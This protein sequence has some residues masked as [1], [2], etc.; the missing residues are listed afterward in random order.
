MRDNHENFSGFY[1]QEKKIDPERIFYHNAAHAEIRE[2]EAIDFF[3]SKSEN[4]MKINR[5]LRGGAK[6]I[7]EAQ[8]LIKS[9]EFLKVKE[10][11]LSDFRKFNSKR[12]ENI[13]KLNALLKNKNLP[14]IKK[15]LNTG[16]D[17][18]NLRYL[19]ENQTQENK[20]KVISGEQ[21]EKIKEVR[22]TSYFL[23]KEE[24]SCIRNQGL[25]SFDM[26]KI[27]EN[28]FSV[29]EANNDVAQ[30]IFDGDSSIFRIGDYAGTFKKIGSLEECLKYK[31]ELSGD[32]SRSSI[33]IS[34][35][36]YCPEYMI[37][38][39]SKE[40]IIEL[41]EKE[42]DSLKAM[43]DKY[44]ITLDY[45]ENNTG[46]KLFTSEVEHGEKIY[47]SKLDPAKNNEDYYLIVNILFNES[48]INKKI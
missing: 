39:P 15:M 31:I 48:M 27:L 45:F 30:N 6:E 38:P 4:T 14:M 8:E 18:I 9:D 21:L 34:Y 7:Y 23:T 20:D 26:K 41:F 2:G 42:K 40:N 35:R 12:E 11:L 44:W 16:S 24:E 46:P 43:A 17:I 5:S 47:F 3:S 1:E 25:I 29:F 37:Q 28:N 10:I 22:D 33:G 32:Y 36:P 19:I 13:K